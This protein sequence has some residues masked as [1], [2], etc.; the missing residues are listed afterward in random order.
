MEDK[1]KEEPLSPQV[2]EAAK[3]ET[4]GT[5]FGGSEDFTPD[6]DESATDTDHAEKEKDA[7]D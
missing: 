7:R 4:R 1:K 3:N 2:K 6:K 5:A